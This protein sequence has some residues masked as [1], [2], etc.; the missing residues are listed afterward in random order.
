MLHAGKHLALPVPPT[1]QPTEP[2]LGVQACDLRARLL[3]AKLQLT[4]MSMLWK[5]SQA[6]TCYCPH[7]QWQL[8]SSAD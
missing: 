8:S 7:V 3:E 2:L 5:E 6:F 4:E 1:L